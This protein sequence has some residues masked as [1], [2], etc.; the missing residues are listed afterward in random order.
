M[1]FVLVN[2]PVLL[3][4]FNASSPPVCVLP[5]WFVAVGLALSSVSAVWWWSQRQCDK[6]CADIPLCSLYKT[7]LTVYY[8]HERFITSM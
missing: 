1:L 4:V 2:C 5:C 6:R 7:E 8:R 3:G